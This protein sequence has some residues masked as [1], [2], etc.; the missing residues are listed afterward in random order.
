[1]T[2]SLLCC[3]N[4]SKQYGPKNHVLFKN[5]SF[6]LFPKE[7]LYVLG[8]NGRGKTTLLKILAGL[9]SFELGEVY[10]RG[11]LFHPYKPSLRRFI[12]WVPSSESSFFS[13]ATAEQNL[14]F[15]GKFFHM[16][17]K[18]I[19]YRAFSLGEALGLEKNDFQVP[20]Q[21]LSSGFKKRFSILRA[22]L[23][24]PII[25]L[26][27]EPFAFLDQK[28]LKKIK[29]FLWDWKNHEERGVIFSS[30]IELPLEKVSKVIKLE[31]YC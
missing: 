20:F 17:Q 23:P 16:D 24:D 22:L 13:F 10:V 30:H 7:I 28:S 27:D 6:E 18:M 2:E 1:M 31:A 15:W 14:L 19:Q 29:A 21:E 9:L 8:D 5:L 4:L 25:L 3:Q 26:L 11:Q 12:G